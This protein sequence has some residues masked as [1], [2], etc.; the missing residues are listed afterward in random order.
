M[1]FI[2]PDKVFV[3]G[4]NDKKVFYFDIKH[5]IFIGLKDLNIIRIEPA[6]QIMGN[7]LF[8]FDNFNKAD[9]EKLSFEKIDINNPNKE[10]ELINPIINGG[11]FPQKL[12]A[13]SKDKTDENII[14]LGG[15]MD[16]ENYSKDLYNY[17]YNIKSNLIEQTNIPFIDF[18]YKEK[19]FLTFNKNVDFLFP[20]FNKAHPKITFYVKNKEKFEKLSY[21]PKTEINDSDNYIQKDN[22]I[23]FAK[24]N[25]KNN[26]EIRK[27]F[28]NIKAYFEF[29]IKVENELKTKKK[30]KIYHKGYLIEKDWIDKWKH[31]IQ[32]ENIKADYLISNKADK[33]IRDKLLNILKEK[34][35]KLVDLSEIKNHEFKEKQEIKEYLKMNSLVIVD[36]DFINSFEQNHSLNQINYILYENTIEIDFG[37]NN[38]IKFNT[39]DNILSRDLIDNENELIKIGKKQYKEVKEIFHSKNRDNNDKN[40]NKQFSDYSKLINENI[41]KSNSNSEINNKAEYINQIDELKKNI[42]VEKE[43]NN[44]LKVENKKLEIIINSLKSENIELKKKEKEINKLKEKIKELEN[45]MNDKNNEIKNYISEINYL[46]ESKNQIKSIKP[47]EKIFSVLF[48][49]QG[50]ND[51]FNYSMTCKN[52]ELFVRLEERLYDDFPQYKNIETIFMVD[53]RRLKRFQTLDENN[54]KRNDIISLFVVDLD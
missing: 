2:S 12:F 40:C 44:K 46:K 26:I 54:I 27:A 1:I 51:I 48:M 21:L 38:S 22:V 33:E 9:N 50:N 49:T 29:E 25:Q 37:L 34:E 3:V 23:Q 13:V 8:C 32:Y 24:N 30:P 10:W 17:K 18:N 45:V 43:N 35:Y 47:G 36:C 15:N 7:I 53:T 39:K 5:K 52:T 6:L 11:K 42:L 16:E 14:F 4:G 20:D 28:Q 19:T 41:N 31:Q